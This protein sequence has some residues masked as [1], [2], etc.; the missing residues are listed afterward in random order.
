MS[1]GATLG[2]SK[3]VE[4]R[5][6]FWKQLS[7]LGSTMGTR[8]DFAAMVAL[9]GT[10]Q[11]RPIVDR[12]LPLEQAIDAHRVMEDGQQFGKIVLVVDQRAG[13]DTASAAG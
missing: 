1:Y 13:T 12:R 4:V 6:I 10:R 2:P 5:R 9:C 3:Q 8:D 7:V 11:L